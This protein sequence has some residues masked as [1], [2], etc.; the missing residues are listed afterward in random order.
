[1]WLGKPGGENPI[2]NEVVESELQD[3][4]STQVGNQAG[5]VK[6]DFELNMAFHNPI[7]YWL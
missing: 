3:K 6:D 1:M 2:V 5:V 7:M 4:Q